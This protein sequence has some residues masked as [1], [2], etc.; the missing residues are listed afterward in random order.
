MC[1]G[2]AGSKASCR[3]GTRFPCGPGWLSG[4]WLSGADLVLLFP[5][6]SDTIAAP[7]KMAAATADPGAGSP[8]VGDSSGGATGCGLPSPGEQELS[9]RLQRLYPA[10]NQHE[11]PL[12]RS[13]SPKDKYNYIGLSQGNLRVHYKGI[14]L[15]A[16]G[17]KRPDCPQGSCA[18]QPVLHHVP[19]PAWVLWVG[20]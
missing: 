7:S 19:S 11:T 1:R 13:W 18:A 6:P 8:Q 14:G 15:L 12:P 4:H 17:R 9:R 16:E 5:A 3:T 2:V 10:V 20:P